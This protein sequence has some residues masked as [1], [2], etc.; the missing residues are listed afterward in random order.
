MPELAKGLG[1]PV[2]VVVANRLGVLNHTLRTIESIRARGLKCLGV[3]LNNA[4]PPE[5][6]SELSQRHNLDDLQQLLPHLPVVGLPYL[7]SFDRR[8]LAEAGQAIRKKLS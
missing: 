1:Y 7:R 3:V 4:H 2:L 6:S 8:V 5:H